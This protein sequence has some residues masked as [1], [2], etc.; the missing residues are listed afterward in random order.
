VNSSSLSSRTVIDGDLAT[1]IRDHFTDSYRNGLVIYGIPVPEKPGMERGVVIYNTSTHE[2]TTVDFQE[3]Y[4]NVYHPVDQDNENVLIKAV[5]SNN[6]PPDLYVLGLDGTT[7][8]KMG[9]SY[10]RDPNS[11]DSKLIPGGLVVAASDVR[12]S[13]GHAS[14]LKRYSFGGTEVWSKVIPVSGQP[15]IKLQEGLNDILALTLT[16]RNDLTSFI[17]YFDVEK[18]EQLYAQL[19]ETNSSILPLDT[20]GNFY[21]YPEWSRYPE[22]P[23]PKGLVVSYSY[24]NELGSVNFNEGIYYF[25]ASP[26]GKYFAII[27]NNAMSIFSKTE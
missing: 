23:A 11:D 27:S 2:K 20:I 5:K 7:K 15:H 10:S 9:L 16:D 25:A 12:S 3:E 8:L 17:G 24:D 4:Q 1:I 21:V 26:S 22:I 14:I 13:N 6:E 18:G 19:F